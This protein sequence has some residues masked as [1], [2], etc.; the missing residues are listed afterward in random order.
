MSLKF[1]SKTHAL[2]A[3]FDVRSYPEPNPEAANKKI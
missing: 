3:R 2:E 1:G